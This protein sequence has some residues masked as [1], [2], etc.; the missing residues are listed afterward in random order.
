MEPAL[1]ADIDRIRD[2]IVRDY[3]PEKIIL[4]GS[5]AAGNARPDSDV[6]LL[7]VKRTSAPYFDRVLKVRRA[8]AHERTIDIIV[9][10]PAELEEAV[11]DNRYLVT[12]EILPKGV[13]LYE[14]SRPR[15]RR[16]RVA[17]ARV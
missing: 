1:K 10:T 11:R 12:Q 16:S 15:R 6:D 5:A 17:A 7:I 4:F 9:L 3:A 13:V 8:L 2:K 14:R